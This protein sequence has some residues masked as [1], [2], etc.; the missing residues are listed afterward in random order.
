MFGF[1]Q[2]ITVLTG[3]ALIIE[4]CVR[5]WCDDT[6]NGFLLCLTPAQKD[7]LCGLLDEMYG[8]LHK[9]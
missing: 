8:L 6:S 5:A 9:H 7:E 2:L 1:G 4:P 3:I